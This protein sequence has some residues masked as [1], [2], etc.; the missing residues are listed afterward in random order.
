[1]DEPAP[2]AVFTSFGSSTL[3]LEL[4]AYLPS[5]DNYPT[6]QHE[7]NVEI[8]RRFRDAGLEIAF[9]QQD[10]HIRSLPENLAVMRPESTSSAESQET[11]PQEERR[12]A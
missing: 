6:V 9:P 7:L 11:V 2:A 10:I 1:M 8:E 4:R 12:A 5:R 3:D